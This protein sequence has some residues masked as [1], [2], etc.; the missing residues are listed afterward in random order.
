MPWTR[1]GYLRA[2]GRL[3]P[4][5][6]LPEGGLTA[7]PLLHVR[8]GRIVL[9]E[10]ARTP[11]GAVRRLAELAAEFAADQPV[12]LAVQYLGEA[13]RAEDLAGQLTRRIPRVRHAYLAAAGPVICAH[14]GPGM[15][16][17]VVA[18]G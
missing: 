1:P 13:G 11:A 18:P 12:D 8:D 5:P 16:G 6:A 15:L 17:V 14:T 10:K 2:G 9:L 4:T 7:R 3:E